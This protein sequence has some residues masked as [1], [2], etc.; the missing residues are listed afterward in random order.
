M[1]WRMKKPHLLASHIAAFLRIMIF[2]GLL[3]SDGKATHKISAAQSFEYL[4]CDRC[5]R[6]RKEREEYTSIEYL[7]I[8]V[9]IAIGTF[10]LNCIYS[11]REI[12]KIVALDEA[13]SLQVGSTGKRCQ[14]ALVMCRTFHAVRCIFYHGSSSDLLTKNQKQW[15]EAR[16]SPTQIRRSGIH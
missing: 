5:C 4:R 15:F 7:S 11:D 16:F 2:A 8:A 9:M 6:F 14:Q 12:Y 13:W 1:Q 10:A 3:F